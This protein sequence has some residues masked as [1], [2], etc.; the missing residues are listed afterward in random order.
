MAPSWWVTSG[1][2]CLPTATAW[3]NPAASTVLCVTQSPRLGC[4]PSCSVSRLNRQGSTT[5]QCTFTASCSRLQ[6]RNL[7]RPIMFRSH[8]HGTPCT[9][10]VGS[11]HCSCQVTLSHKAHC[12]RLVAPPS[13]LRKRNY[14]QCCSHHTTFHTTAATRPHFIQHSTALTT[15]CKK[16]TLHTGNHTHIPVPNLVKTQTCTLGSITDRPCGPIVSNPG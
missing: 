9:T 10:V 15:P 7:T 12:S 16:F 2:Y 1:Q 13:H 5:S 14:A 3:Q 6:R 11:R 4:P 8:G